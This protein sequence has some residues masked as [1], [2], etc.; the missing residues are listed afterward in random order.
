[1]KWV[2]CSGLPVRIYRRRELV[3]SWHLRGAWCQPRACPI[4]ASLE[5]PALD[6]LLLEPLR[7]GVRP[8]WNGLELALLK[9]RG[10]TPFRKGST[11]SHDTGESPVPSLSAQPKGS[12]FMTKARM[13]GLLTGL[14]LALFVTLPLRASEA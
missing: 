14:V 1:M 11:R 5:A 3:V 6:R 2:D 10:L 4:V 13:K 7:K 12:F 8:L 9:Q